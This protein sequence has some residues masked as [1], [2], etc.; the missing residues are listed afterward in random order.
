MKKYLFTMATA[1]MLF[2][3]CSSDDTVIDNGVNEEGLVEIK[4]GTRAKVGVESRAAIEDLAGLS[5]GIIAANRTDMTDVLL[6][7]IEGKASASST[8]SEYDITLQSENNSKYYYNSSSTAAYDF[9]GYYPYQEDKENGVTFGTNIVATGDF[10]Q[11]LDILAG[12]AMQEVLDNDAQKAY[13]WSAT[14]YKNHRTAGTQATDPN[15]EF[16]HMN[17]RF[18]IEIQRGPA[19]VEET[20]V[21]DNVTM[22]LPETYSLTFANGENPTIA[23]IDENTDATVVAGGTENFTA[24]TTGKLSVIDFMVPSGV[25]THT[26]YLNFLNR[27]DATRIDLIFD[28][29]FTDADNVTDTKFEA[30]KIYTITLTINGPEEI[31]VK[32]TLKPWVAGGNWGLEI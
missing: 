2:A 8:S 21:L 32:A 16:N 10:T 23:Y 25:E 29:L 6:A 19:F 4:L 13:A 17:S 26:F 1:A 30:G 31:T 7:N 20:C 22:N 11:D 24:P 3:S 5:V 14:Y 28:D 18:I 15:I 27:A 9:F 12:R